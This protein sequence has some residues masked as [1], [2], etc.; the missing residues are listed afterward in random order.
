MKKVF[1]LLFTLLLSANLFAGERKICHGAGY[2]FTDR[3][4][5]VTQNDVNVRS[6]PGTNYSK[7]YKVNAGDYVHVLDECEE[8]MFADGAYAHWYKINF[9]GQEG[10]MCGRWLSALYGQYPERAEGEEYI[11]YE[12]IYSRPEPY[13]PD[14]DWENIE[15]LSDRVMHIKDRKITYLDKISFL[16]NKGDLFVPPEIEIVEN[17]GLQGKK[18][19]VIF[20]QYVKYGAGWFRKFE[21]YTLGKNSLSYLLNENSSWEGEYKYI[22][23]VFPDITYD[24]RMDEWIERESPYDSDII[25]EKTTGNSY[26]DKEEVT[27]IFRPGQDPDEL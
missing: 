16:P 5:I 24:A 22:K 14:W 19:V 12:Y 1:I 27:K 26:T 21:I 13:N 2:F 25:I 18:A 8:E 7:L 10:Y 20:N 9:E 4:C 17:S 11:V 15:I 3:C 23:V 6:G